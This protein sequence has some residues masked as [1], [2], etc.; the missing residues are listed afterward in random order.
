MWGGVGLS[1]AKAIAAALT[2]DGV[3]G[4]AV[5][6]DAEAIGRG[7]AARLIK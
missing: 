7:G 2:A 4:S 3:P 5:Q 6:V 1:R